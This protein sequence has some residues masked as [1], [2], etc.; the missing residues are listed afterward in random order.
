MENQTW[1][2]PDIVPLES[3]LEIHI[4]RDENEFRLRFA[5]C[6]TID[7]AKGLISF[8]ETEKVII[9]MSVAVITSLTACHHPCSTTPFIRAP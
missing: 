1:L 7:I 6:L 4:R 3:A 5:T 2:E 8:L 9:V